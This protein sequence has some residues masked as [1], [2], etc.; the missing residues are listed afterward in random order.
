MWGGG[1]VLH[2]SK[3]SAMKMDEDTILL[4]EMLVVS[5]VIMNEWVAVNL[6]F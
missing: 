1:T 5:G 6:E 2:A 3:P 4:D